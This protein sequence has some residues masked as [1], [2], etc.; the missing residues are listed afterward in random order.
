MQPYESGTSPHR[1]IASPHSR[2]IQHFS[3]IIFQL[4]VYGGLNSKE[5]AGKALCKDWGGLGEHGEVSTTV[6][7]RYTA[8]LRFD[9][10]TYIGIQLV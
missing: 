7:R 1:S 4:A 6:L 8:M 9:Q 10:N 5:Q 2:L 3:T